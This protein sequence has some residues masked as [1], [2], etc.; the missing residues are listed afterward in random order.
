[1]QTLKSEVLTVQVS[2]FGAELQSI[3][4]NGYEIGRAH[5]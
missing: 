5:V 4:K 2:D 3:A 1:M